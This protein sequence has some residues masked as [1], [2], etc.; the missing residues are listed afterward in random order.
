MKSVIGVM[1]WRKLREITLDCPRNVKALK[2]V[3]C[4]A[5]FQQLFCDEGPDGVY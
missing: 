5:E 1:T 3:K 2:V 4:Q